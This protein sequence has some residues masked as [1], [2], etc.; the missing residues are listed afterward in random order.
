[1]ASF[2]VGNKSH[3]IN[4]DLAA[5]DVELAVEVLQHIYHHHGRRRRAY[6]G[7]SNDVAEKH[8]HVFVGLRLDTFT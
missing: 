8:R 6:R 5:E 7:K 4:I 3:L 1:M 2:R